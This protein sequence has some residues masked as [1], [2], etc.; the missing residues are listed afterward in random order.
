MNLLSFSITRFGNQKKKAPIFSYS[1][2]Y[3]RCEKRYES[4]KYLICDIKD[5]QDFNQKS[6]FYTWYRKNDQTL[7]DV[8]VF[9]EQQTNKMFQNT[10][11]FFMYPQYILNIHRNVLGVSQPQKIHLRK[12]TIVPDSFWHQGNR[13]I[14]LEWTKIYVTWNDTS[15]YRMG[16]IL[17]LFGVFFLSFISNKDQVHR[18]CL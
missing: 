16:K 17:L 15:D 3:I 13:S 1:Y 11:L 14:A 5:I 10:P 12:Q 2:M 9:L 18:F 8:S 6:H 7:T 4:R